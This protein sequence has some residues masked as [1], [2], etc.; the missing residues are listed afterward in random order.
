M[1]AF[2]CSFPYVVTSSWNFS[3]LRVS[4]IKFPPHPHPHPQLPNTAGTA[5]P[6]LCHPILQRPAPG[7]EDLVGLGAAHSTSPSPGM[8]FLQRSSHNVRG[9]ASSKAST[10]VMVNRQN[11]NET[12]RHSLYGRRGIRNILRPT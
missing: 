7:A 4:F 10:N 6:L 9:Q 8:E 1:F 11:F 12:E 3:G 5:A 2:S